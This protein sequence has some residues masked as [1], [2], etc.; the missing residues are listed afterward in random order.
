MIVMKTGRK[1]LAE[2]NLCNILANVTSKKNACK[3]LVWNFDADV[4]MALLEKLY[5]SRQ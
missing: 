3:S 1:K 4:A 2:M 5:V